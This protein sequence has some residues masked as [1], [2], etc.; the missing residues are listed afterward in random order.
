MYVNFIALCVL[1]P[2]SGERVVHVQPYVYRA[3]A[4]QGKQRYCTGWTQQQMHVLYCA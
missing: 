4:R 3:G 2:R 1:F